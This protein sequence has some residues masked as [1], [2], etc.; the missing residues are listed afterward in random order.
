MSPPNHQQ[1]IKITQMK[2]TVSISVIRIS[3]QFAFNWRLWSSFHLRNISYVRWAFGYQMA[4]CFLGRPN[5]FWSQLDVIGCSIWFTSDL[6]QLDLPKALDTTAGTRGLSWGE[7]WKSGIQPVPVKIQNTRNLK[8]IIRG[9]SR[10]NID[11][12]KYSTRKNRNH[13]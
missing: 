13:K 11:L 3:R 9:I 7:L 10:N 1:L 12:A 2:W 6:L 8:F 4:V 5:V